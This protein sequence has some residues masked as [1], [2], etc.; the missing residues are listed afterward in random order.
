M[1]IDDNSYGDL[2][3]IGA[4]VPRYANASGTFDTTTRPTGSTV[5]TQIDQVSSIINSLLA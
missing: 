1:A 3:S 5:E 4:L 2:A